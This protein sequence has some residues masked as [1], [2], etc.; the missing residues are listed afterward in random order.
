MALRGGKLCLRSLLTPASCAACGCEEVQ[1]EREIARLRDAKMGGI[2]AK[3]DA[4][5]KGITLLSLK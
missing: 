1:V 4:Q 5:D 2:S 3:S